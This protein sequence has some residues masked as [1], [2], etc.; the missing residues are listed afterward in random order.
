M[1]IRIRTLAFILARRTRGTVIRLSCRALRAGL[2]AAPIRART[3]VCYHRKFVHD[4]HPN[5]SSLLPA[6]R[7]ASLRTEGLLQGQRPARTHAR[8]LLE[9]LLIDLSWYS[10]RLEG[11][12][13]SLLDTRDLFVKGRSAGDDLY[14]TMLLNHGI[15]CV[16]NCCTSSHTTV[17]GIGFQSARPKNG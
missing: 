4:Q 16:P 15:A 3:S 17:L 9:Q 10:S 8:K 7:A 11:N 13:K 2:E 5:H 6:A 14:T 12:R 1:L